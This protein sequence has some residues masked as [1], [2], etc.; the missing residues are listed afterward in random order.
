MIF[1]SFSDISPYQVQNLCSASLHRTGDLIGNVDSLSSIFSQDGYISHSKTIEVIRNRRSAIVRSQAF[2]EIPNYISVTTFAYYAA[3][4]PFYARGK[5]QELLMAFWTHRIPFIQPITVAELAADII[6]DALKQYPGDTDFVICDFASGAGGPTP[7][8]ER[9]VN[10]IRRRQGKKPLEF[11]LSD[12]KPNLGE[13]KKHKATSP[14][15]DYVERPVDAANPPPEVISGG[16]SGRGKKVF[17]LY[18]LSFHHFDDPLAAK[19]L[20]STME[21]ADGFA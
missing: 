20:Q 1:G 7:T 16:K 11:L 6:L 12:I 14:Y 9:V 21:T 13:W 3:S 5:V 8:I 10:T 18:C 2:T 19:I 17:R 15:I 4:M